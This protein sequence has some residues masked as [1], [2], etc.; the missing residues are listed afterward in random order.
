MPADTRPAPDR[1]LGGAVAVIALLAIGVVAV[2]VALRIGYP[3][4]LEW[5]EGAMVDHAARVRAG[6][7]IYCA[8]SP[9]HVSFLYTP[10]LF[11]LGAL[12]SFVTGMGFLALR[13]VSVLA[14]LGCAVL[15]WRWAAREAGTRLAGLLAAGLFC[16]GYGYLRTWYDLARNDTLFLVFVIAAAYL[17]RFHGRRAA[18]VAGV[19]TAL[20]FLAKQSA[21]MWLPAIFTGALL[22]DWRKGLWFGVS[23]GIAL[24]L[25]ILTGHLVTVG[26]FTFF[27]FEMPG[28]HAWQGDRKLA[29]FTEDLVPILPMVAG[30]LATGMLRIRNGRR[31]EGLFLLAFGGGGLLTSYLSRLHAGG[32]DN[33]MMHA[34][35]GGC[36]LLPALLGEGRARRA[37]ILLVLVQFLFLTFDVRAVWQ[38]GRRALLFDPAGA[39][40]R[41]AHR[42]ASEELLAFLRAEPDAVLLPSHGWIAPMAGKPAWS[43][44]QAIF[45]LLQGL[46]DPVTETFDPGRIAVL[47]PR[48]R[49]ALQHDF[50]EPFIALLQA[51]HWSAIVLD[52]QD[53]GQ[54]ENL[55]TL[56][57]VGYRQR[58]RPILS[59]PEA[60]RPLVGREID[61]PIVL[62]RKP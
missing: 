43:H 45:D 61:S 40:P 27:V 5:M 21:L 9:E 4:E 2:L 23:A 8:P 51:R 3:F 15:V 50:F 6:L 49:D 13:L 46:V 31:G 30:A 62:E 32:Y 22:L 16:A 42:Q 35:A 41:P 52:R 18:V 55:F 29:F 47:S 11:Q 34:L 54:F 60:L 36:M 33:V 28:H 26:W 7:P 59:H 19:L 20:A 58:E 57:L 56:G 17:L 38:P 14:S 10:L 39:L 44:G 53:A 1:V 48:Y 12:V 37:G 24:G 25:T